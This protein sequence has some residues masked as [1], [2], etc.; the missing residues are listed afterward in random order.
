MIECTATT[1]RVSYNGEPSTVS[2]LCCSLVPRLLLVVERGNKPGYEA[3]C[4][5]KL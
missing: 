3:T 2:I 5:V 4:A 1:S